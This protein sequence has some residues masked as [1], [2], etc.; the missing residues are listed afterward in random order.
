MNA[1]MLGLRPYIKVRET[2]RVGVCFPLRL[3]CK[4][5]VELEEIFVEVKQTLGSYERTKSYHIAELFRGFSSWS[6]GF[7]KQSQG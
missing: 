3:K 2:F 6:Y 7:F 5:L 4:K 1:I